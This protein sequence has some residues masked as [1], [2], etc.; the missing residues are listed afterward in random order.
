MGQFRRRC[1]I[2]NAASTS[3]DRSPLIQKIASTVST[4]AD[5]LAQAAA[6]AADRSWLVA[7]VQ[8]G[9]RGR[10]GRVWES[11]AGNLYASNLVRLGAGDPPAPTLALVAGIAVYDAVVRFVADRAVML[12]WPNDILLDGAKLGGILLERQDDAVIVGVGIN[13]AAAP[14]IRDRATA[15]LSRQAM[16][17]DRDAVLAALRKSMDGW[18]SCWRYGPMGDIIGA[19]SQRAFP[20]GSALSLTTGASGRL[21]GHFAG[22]NPD[23]SLRLGLGDGR[24]VDIHAGDVELLKEG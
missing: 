19:W 14:A 9:G 1:T 5:L 17:I 21:S 22:L 24:I 12:K 2:L 15:R 11:A 23:G 10:M 4:N 7:D 8:T 16:P 6:G 13:V 20:V 3:P 18:L